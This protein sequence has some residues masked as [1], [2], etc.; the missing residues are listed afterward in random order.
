MN[1]SWISMIL[2]INY[3]FSI[4]TVINETGFLA[5]CSMVGY[6]NLQY[7]R[8]FS[9]LILHIRTAEPFNVLF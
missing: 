2:V 5:L 7:R 3:L 1:E 6:N 8:C 4:T 9:F